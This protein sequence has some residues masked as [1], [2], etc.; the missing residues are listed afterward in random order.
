MGEVTSIQMARRQAVNDRAETEMEKLLGQARFKLIETGTR[1]RLIHTP[2]GNKRSRALPIMGNVSDQVFA[3][4]V[5]ENS[6]PPRSFSIRPRPRP[7]M[8]RTLLIIPA[9]RSSQAEQ[10]EPLI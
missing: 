10:G 3:N 4:L 5:R 1:N 6:P 8:A 7:N 9:W 2:R